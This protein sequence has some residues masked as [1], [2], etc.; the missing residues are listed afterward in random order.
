MPVGIMSLIATFFLQKVKNIDGI[1]ACSED[2]KIQAISHQIWGDK[3]AQVRVLYKNTLWAATDY[4][5]SGYSM[6]E[7]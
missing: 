3:I 4:N 7:R 1:T 6:M 5:C 2:P